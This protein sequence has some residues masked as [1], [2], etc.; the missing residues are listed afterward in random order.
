MTDQQTTA[1]AAPVSQQERITILDSLRGIAILGILLMNIPGFGFPEVQA[2]DPSVLNET[3]INYKTWY[4]VDWAL[5]GTQRAIFS[6]LFGAGIIL[7]ITRLEKRMDGMQAAIYFF[8]RQ[9]WLLAFG[10]F[11][12]FVLLWFWDILYAYA[13]FGMLLF[14]FY[15]KSPKTL[16][17][18][19]F[20]C[21]VLMTV[22]ENVNLYRGK[23]TISKGEL[24]TKADTTQTKLTIQQKEDLEALN[25]MKEE[26]SK[27]AKLKK[28]EKELRAIGGNYASLYKMQSDKSVHVELYYTYFLAWDVLLFMFLGMAFFK[29]G[30][31][32]GNASVKIYWLMFIGGLGLGL[33]LSY[34]NQ[35]AVIDTHFSEYEYTKKVQFNFF[36]V[37]RMLRSL[38][39]FGLIML[40]YKS[41]WF[42]RLFDLF[43]PVGQM[44]FTNYLMQSLLGALFFYGIGLGYFGKLERY[45]LYFYVAVV[46]II[47]I[48]W[49]HIWLRYFR[50][51]P[52]EWLWRSLNYWKK[53]PLRKTNSST[54]TMGIG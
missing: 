7:F 31:L 41:G 36:Q 26:S 40:L 47:E 5:T 48:I 2:S 30:I 12:A 23:T 39:F 21:L 8:R 18:L 27:E 34:F 1:L 6:M 42:K 9:M 43:R 33:L 22:R 4:I 37:Q 35:K 50:F 10:L 32:T 3:G 16:F 51:G 38:G 14:V 53:Q 28:H 52:L 15:R 19:A 11:N 45:E 54:D 49:S 13:I 29:T 46:W 44:A 25:G 20:V 24:V 17:I